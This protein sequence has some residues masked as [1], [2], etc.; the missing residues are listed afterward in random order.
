MKK[1]YNEIADSQIVGT[2]LELDNHIRQAMD[3]V[4]GL[5]T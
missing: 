1:M 2:S 3:K 4:H 5:F